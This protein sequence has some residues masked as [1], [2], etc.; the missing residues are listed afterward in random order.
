MFNMYFWHAK[1]VKIHNCKLVTAK[2]FQTYIEEF[3]Y[4]KVIIV[5]GEPVA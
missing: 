2:V 1:A 5:L 3:S 4:V